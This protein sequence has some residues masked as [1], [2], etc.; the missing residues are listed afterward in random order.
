M[1]QPQTI[2]DEH[3][4]DVEWDPPLTLNEKF[5]FPQNPE[6]VM[7]ADVEWDYVFKLPPS[8]ITRLVLVSKTAL[9]K[10]EAHIKEMEQRVIHLEKVGDDLAQQTCVA[11]QQI[12]YLGEKLAENA[13]LGASL[14]LLPECTALIRTPDRNGP[15]EWTVIVGDYNKPDYSC[16]G[17]TPEEALRN[18]FQCMAGES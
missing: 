3:Q 17:S 5:Q 6:Y 18:L 12:N 8:K 9:D 15:Q 2:G 10:T 16:Y 13:A 1:E 7:D 4:P 11:D 14:R